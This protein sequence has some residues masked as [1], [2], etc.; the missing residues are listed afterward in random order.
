MRAANRLTQYQQ[1]PKCLTTTLFAL[2]SCS[3]GLQ[4][5]GARLQQ[6]KISITV[7]VKM[8][9]M[10]FDSTRGFFFLPYLV[11]RS[12]HLP[13]LYVSESVVCG[14]CH[15]CR[16]SIHRGRLRPGRILSVTL[17]SAWDF[18]A[19]EFLNSEIVLLFVLCCIERLSHLVSMVSS[20][21]LGGYLAWC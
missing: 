21:L 15:Y 3:D 4:L 1:E 2:D 11:R 16:T 7:C 9:V 19:T 6:Q 12:T 5:L 8:R 18:D 17:A 20:A 14:L 10:S 13:G